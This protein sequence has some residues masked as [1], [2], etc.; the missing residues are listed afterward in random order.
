MPRPL[1][2]ALLLALLTGLS[3][4]AASIEVTELESMQELDYGGGEQV[5][6][7]R[8]F[9]ITYKDFGSGSRTLVFVHP[10]G[11]NMKIWEQVA[12]RFADDHRIVMLDLPGHGKSSKPLNTRYDVDLGAGIVIELLDHLQ[13]GKV[14][15]IG[16]S[17]GGGV[18]LAVIRDVPQRVERLVLVDA[19]GGGTPPGLFA[20]FINEFFTAPMF[21]AVDEGLIETAAN[22]YAWDERT[23]A[24]DAFLADLLGARRS[25]D[26]YAYALAV[27]HYLRTAVNYDATPWLAHIAVP[28]LVIWG[29][30][31]WILWMDGA[32]TFVENIPDARLVVIPDC[33]HMPQLEEPDAFSEVLRE[34]LQATGPSEPTA[35]V[36]PSDPET[37]PEDTDDD[38]FEFNESPE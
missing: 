21:A 27:S 25:K 13:L 32:E 29:D 31:D 36:N 23:P 37:P 9:D 19:L 34:F 38:A 18:S 1:L 16:N 24:T 28:T 8:G 14:T 6:T 17:L 4:C 33:G 12:P 2:I 15:L 5:V 11:T 10:W 3:A 26:G 22:L 20:F 30:N 7:L 35:P